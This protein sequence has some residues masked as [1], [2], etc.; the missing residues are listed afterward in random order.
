VLEDFRERLMVA[1]E[2]KLEV[3][4]QEL[5]NNSG[6]GGGCERPMGDLSCSAGVEGEMD[7][8]SSNVATNVS[9]CPLPLIST[10]PVG[11]KRAR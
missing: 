5:S 11:L 6:R 7:L 1:F 9:I 3:V 10:P 8:A 2:V 4:V